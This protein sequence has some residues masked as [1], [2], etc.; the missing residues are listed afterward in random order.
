MQLVSIMHMEPSEWQM[1]IH[2]HIASK[3]PETCVL[4]CKYKLFKLLLTSCSILNIHI[5]INFIIILIIMIIIIT[6]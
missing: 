2:I 6:R 5:I 4:L 1:T 3:C